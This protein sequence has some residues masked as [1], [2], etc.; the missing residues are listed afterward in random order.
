MDQKKELEKLASYVRLTWDRKLTESTGGNMSVRIDDRIYITPT[1]FVKHYFTTEDMVVVD[2]E[3]NKLS[4]KLNPSSEIRM[5]LKLYQTRPDIKSV[6]HAH[7]RYGLICVINQIKV[8]PRVLPEMILM[9]HDIAYLPYHLP[10][11]DEF[12]EAFVKDAQKGTNVFMLDNH[13]VTTCGDSIESAF[14]RL[15]TLETCAYIMVMQE[16][17]GKK[18]NLISEAETQRFKKLVGIE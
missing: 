5:H 1:M 15:E 17:L 11:T 16:M 8:N 18:P 12:A 9:L 13:G 6:F 3:G 14:Y 7:P 4:G 2:M 10:G